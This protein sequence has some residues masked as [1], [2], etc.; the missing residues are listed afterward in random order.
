MELH[1]V[2]VAAGADLSI[3]VSGGDRP[4]VG[5]VALA[6]PHRSAADPARQSATTSALVRAHHRDDQIARTFADR[7]AREFGVAVAVSAG[8]HTDGL[9][10]RGIETYLALAERLADALVRAIH[11]HS[12]ASR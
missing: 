10:A 8:V 6:E 4:H 11:R 2:A 1:A 9:D 5:S 3:T 12:P 7:L